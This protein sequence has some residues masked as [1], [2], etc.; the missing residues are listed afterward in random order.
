M[1]H[2]LR[3][4]KKK[5]T[6]KTRLLALIPL[7]IG[8]LICISTTL[9]LSLKQ[10]DSEKSV[11][12]GKIQFSMDVS[13]CFTSNILDEVINGQKLLDEICFY[14]EENSVPSYVRMRFV[15]TTENNDVLSSSQLK[16]I[17]KLNNRVTTFIGDTYDWSE[18][19]GDYFYLLE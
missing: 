17:C 4:S 12:I 13:S 5:L 3:G 18:R 10:V 15:Y 16:Y 2:M 14:K 1:K 7:V 9:A 6:S 8:V 19:R 11:N